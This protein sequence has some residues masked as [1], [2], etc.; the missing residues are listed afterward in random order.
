MTVNIWDWKVEL[1]QPCNL[2]LFLASQGECL[3]VREGPQ[4]WPTYSTRIISGSRYPGLALGDQRYPSS[5]LPS[6]RAWFYAHWLNTAHSEDRPQEELVGA[7]RWL[8]G[9][10][11]LA[12]HKGSNPRV[13]S[14]RA[15]SGNTPSCRR[16]PGLHPPSASDGPCDF[17]RSRP[18]IG[19]QFLHL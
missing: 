1:L 7:Q 11:S 6:L 18:I 2:L 8:L 5:M 3:R 10:G 17:V 12:F 14:G 13:L 9:V 4:L 19:P 16:K 15:G